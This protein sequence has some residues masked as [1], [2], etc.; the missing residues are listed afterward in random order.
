MNL[1]WQGFDS[2]WNNC[3]IQLPP[4]WTSPFTHYSDIIPSSSSLARVYSAN[5]NRAKFPDKDIIVVQFKP[6]EIYI[7]KQTPADNFWKK[8]RL[9]F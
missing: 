1:K 5:L 8:L 2:L 6:T 3:E 9:Q 7:W 4:P